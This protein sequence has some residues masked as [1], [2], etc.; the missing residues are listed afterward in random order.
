MI[1]KQSAMAAIL[2]F[3]NKAKILHGHV[4]IDINTTNIPCKFGEDI[5]TN[6]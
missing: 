4:F 3:Q 6:E 1:F 5:F 2:F